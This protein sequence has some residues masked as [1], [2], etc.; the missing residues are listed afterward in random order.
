MPNEFDPYNEWLGIP[1]ENQPPN[2]Y[3]LLGIDLFNPDLKVINDAASQRYLHV[4]S[5]QTRDNAAL[6]KRILKE[7]IIAGVCLLTPE[8]KANIRFRTKTINVKAFN[9]NRTIA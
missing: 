8:K 2:Y 4:Q 6:V 7:I 5:F 9:R 1:P 3:R